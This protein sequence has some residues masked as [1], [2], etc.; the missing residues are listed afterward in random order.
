[1]EDGV[2]ALEREAHRVAITDVGADELDLGAQVRGAVA[3]GVNLGVQAVQRSHAVPAREEL[4]REVRSDEA[5][6]AGDEHRLR[7]ATLRPLEKK[8]KLP[9]CSGSFSLPCGGFSNRPLPA[10]DL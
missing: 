3:A 9:L 10:L 5:C 6:P 2:A 7:H 4:V 8:A 1:M